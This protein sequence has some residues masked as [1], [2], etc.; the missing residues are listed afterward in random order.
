MAALSEWA[1]HRYRLRLGF[2]NSDDEY[3]QR[4]R[5]SCDRD[6]DSTAG[7]HGNYLSASHNINDSNEHNHH[8]RAYN[9]TGATDKPADKHDF[10]VDDICGRPRYGPRLRFRR[11]WDR[12]G[13][14]NGTGRFRDRSKATDAHG[15]ANELL[16]VLWKAHIVQLTIL[17]ILRKISILIRQ[18]AVMNVGNS[19]SLRDCS[20]HMTLVVENAVAVKSLIQ[21]KKVR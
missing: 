21:R 5:V 7:N 19:T 9:D 18:L 3:L 14:R 17:P 13:R 20:S 16:S 10:N 8:P 4:W 12:C 6:H 15:R 11:D 1:R 2:P